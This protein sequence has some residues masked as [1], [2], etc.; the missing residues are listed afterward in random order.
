MGKIKV[1]DFVRVK[2]EV[3]EASNSNIELTGWSGR[4]NTVSKRARQWGVLIDWDVPTIN[5]FPEQFIKDAVENVEDLRT[6]FLFMPDIELI[7]ETTEMSGRED[8]ISKLEHDNIA[9]ADDEGTWI[10]EILGTAAIGVNTENLSTYSKYLLKNLEHP[11]E[12]TGREDFPW[13]ERFVLGGHS[14][15]EYQHLRQTHPSYEDTF[16][17]LD[18]VQNAGDN[19]D[20]FAKVKRE[21]DAKMFEIGLS[22]LEPADEDSSNYHLLDLFATWIVNY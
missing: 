13:E 3:R 6:Y 18:I 1:G 2:N 7:A 12:L 14:Q 19:R 17:L 8:L 16:L 11:V 10:S 20:L 15:R 21:E 4:V 9:Y 22:W 5:K